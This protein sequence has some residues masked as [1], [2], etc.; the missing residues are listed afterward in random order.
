MLPSIWRE[1]HL[2]AGFSNLSL[3][4]LQSKGKE[5]GLRRKAKKDPEPS[6]TQAF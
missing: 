5:E 1:K 3:S 6:L 4:R 2:S